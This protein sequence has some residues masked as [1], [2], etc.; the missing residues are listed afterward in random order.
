MGR[1]FLMTDAVEKDGTRLKNRLTGT[2]MH[3]LSATSSRRGVMRF[4]FLVW[5]RK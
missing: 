2:I 1:F 3:I 5:L 4:G